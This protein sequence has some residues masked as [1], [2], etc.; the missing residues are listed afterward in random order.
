VFQK[1]VTLVV[2]LITESIYCWKHNVSS[3]TNS[4]LCPVNNYIHLLRILNFLSSYTEIE[5]GS[6]ILFLSGILLTV[7][8]LDLSVCVK[9]KED[10]LLTFAL[11][12]QD[13][14]ILALKA[15][16]LLRL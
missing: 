7:C 4:I 9:S 8:N 3:L 2:M 5:G 1:G 10:D 12:Y 11:V 13:A 15:P 14:I 6:F 16:F